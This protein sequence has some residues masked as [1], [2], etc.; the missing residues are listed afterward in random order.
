MSYLCCCVLSVVVC[1]FVIVPAHVFDSTAASKL[2][3][4]L[5]CCVLPVVNC[6]FLIIPF[7]I[8]SRKKLVVTHEL[9][10]LLLRSVTRTDQRAGANNQWRSYIHD[11]P[12][13]YNPSS[14]MHT[15]TTG[16]TPYIIHMILW[17][18][19]RSMFVLAF[20]MCLAGQFMWREAKGKVEI[21]GWGVPI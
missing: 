4:N 20:N 14:F 15:A 13:Q 17:T 16:P 11:Q 2:W 1:C 9:S 12:Q 7:H 18:F 21:Q 19:T 8:I 3:A 10:V 5:W 6:C